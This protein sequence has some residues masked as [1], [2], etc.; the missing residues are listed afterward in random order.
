MIGVLR[1]QKADSFALLMDIPLVEL[2]PYAQKA[3]RQQR[4]ISIS[5]KPIRAPQW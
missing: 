3:Q 2:R 1:Q 4:A 5:V